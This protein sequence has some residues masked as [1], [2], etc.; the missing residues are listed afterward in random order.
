MSSLL[1]NGLIVVDAPYSLSSDECMDVSIDPKVDYDAGA[2]IAVQALIGTVWLV[3]NMFVYIKK[4]YDLTLD[5][6]KVY[7]PVAWWWNS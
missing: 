3:M 4:T 6:T 1:Q 7:I 2:L 5:S